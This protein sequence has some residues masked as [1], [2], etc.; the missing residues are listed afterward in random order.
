MRNHCTWSTRSVSTGVRL[1]SKRPTLI[2]DRYNKAADTVD[3]PDLRS[4]MHVNLNVAVMEGDGQQMLVS[5]RRCGR[6]GGVAVPPA[7]VTVTV[8]A[9][10]VS[11]TKRAG[12]PRN[13]NAPTQHHA[14]PRP[15]RDPQFV[16]ASILALI[17]PPSRVLRDDPGGGVG[18]VQDQ[19]DVPAAGRPAPLRMG[20]G[21]GL[22]PRPGGGAAAPG[23]DR[24]DRRGPQGRRWAILG[25]VGGAAGTHAASGPRC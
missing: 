4:A 15:T 9:A 25:A 23:V 17:L 16:V 18:V 7:R 6:R 21:G 12:R 19:P 8:A 1:D 3:S 24:Q 20:P 13:P 22:Q 11:P 10:G 5:H 14:S 2:L